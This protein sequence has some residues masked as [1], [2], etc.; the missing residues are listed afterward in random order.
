MK[1][2][3]YGG[4]FNPIHWGHLEAARAAME[5]LGLNRLYFI[6]AGLPPHKTLDPNTPTPEQRL[7]L[8]RLG[9]AYLGD[10]A[11]ASDLE[12]RRAGKS[13]TLDTVRCLHHR[14][15]KDSLYLLTGADM[16]LT[17]QNWQGPGE[18]LHC[19]TLVG[20]RRSQR[21]NGELLL[22][23]KKYLSK[24]Y[25]RDVKLVELANAVDISSSQIRGMLLRR[26]GREYLP[27]AVYGAILRCHLYGTAVDLKQLPLEDL[28]CVAT[29]MLKHR[30]IGHVLGTENTAAALARRWGVDEE[31]A[32][33]AALLHDCTKKLNAEQQAA[34]CRQ[35]HISLDRFESREEHLLH[36]I[37]GAAVAENIYGLGAEAV[38]AIRWHTTGK[39]HMTTMEKILYLADYIEPT[40]DFDGLAELRT[41]AYQDLDRAVLQGLTL[42]IQTLKKKGMRVHPRSVRARDYL[43]GTLT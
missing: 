4:T 7:E 17:F 14:Y 13:Y 29:S 1:L 23:Q 37:T 36:A 21:D 3:I 27:P 16:F 2:G 40:R 39:E 38:S 12:I 28:R 33:R 35:Y 25:R 31:T 18:I 15:P 43:K 26:E 6:P 34:L 10:G 32:R 41:L 30:R 11:M 42:S 22:A 20:F 8:T 5:Q 24:R 9:A 19:C